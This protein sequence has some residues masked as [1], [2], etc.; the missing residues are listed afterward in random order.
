MTDFEMMRKIY[1]N[2]CIEHEII[3]GTNGAFPMIDDLYNKILYWF[4]KD[5][6]LDV[7]D[8]YKEVW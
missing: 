3:D 7:I 6:S 5:G 4:N 8:N 1:E 2:S